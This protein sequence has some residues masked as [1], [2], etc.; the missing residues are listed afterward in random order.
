MIENFFTRCSLY[1][2]DLL[3]KKNQILTLCVDSGT[4]R[5]SHY[6]SDTFHT[7]RSPFPGESSGR[8]LK[9]NRPSKKTTL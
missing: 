2:K 3:Q 4:R 7:P 5:K 6:K 8:F 9:K 1:D